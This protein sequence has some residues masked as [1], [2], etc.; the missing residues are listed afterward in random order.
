[1]NKSLFLS[2]KIFKIILSQKKKKKIFKIII[3]IKFYYQKFQ[4][5]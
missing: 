4:G 2:S 5:I 3:H 1:M